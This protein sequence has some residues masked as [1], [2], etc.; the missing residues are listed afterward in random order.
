MWF[1][2]MGKYLKQDEM[3]LL[4]K[5]IYFTALK[6]VFKATRKG[7][8]MTKKRGNINMH[9][10]RCLLNKPTSAYI[11]A[12]WAALGIGVV[13]YLTGLWNAAI[14]LNEK[15]YYFAVFLLAMFSAVTLQKTV[16]DRDEGLPVTNVF[17]GMSWAVF[18]AAIALLCIGLFNA[19]MALSEK[20]FYGISFILSLFSMITV[21]KNVRDM[22]DEYGETDPSA[23]QGVR[24][25]LDF[26]NEAVDVLDR[27]ET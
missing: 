24:R 19:E 12:S 27:I 10:N 7:M 5:S 18:F 26:A 16:R 6:F 23:F 2:I 15:G 4:I 8:T 20:G 9:L 11:G 3:I 17:L 1:V 22:T 21:Q 14:Q 25:G 13:T